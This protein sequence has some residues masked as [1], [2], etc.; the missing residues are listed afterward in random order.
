MTDEPFCET[1]ASRRVGIKT[2]ARIL[3]NL[4]I[5]TW[6]EHNVIEIYARHCDNREFIKRDKFF[7]IEAIWI[8][9]HNLRLG[10]WNTQ[11]KSDPARHAE[12]HG[13]AS[14]GGLETCLS[15]PPNPHSARP[16]A[17]RFARAAARSARPGLI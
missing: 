17:A 16:M 7:S 9:Q 11:T 14:G 8:T 5:T 13:G 3:T 2:I 12:H 10:P 15:C 1:D 6:E 4:T